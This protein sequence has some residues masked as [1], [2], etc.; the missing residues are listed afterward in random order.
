MRKWNFTYNL[1]VLN[2]LTQSFV[3]HPLNSILWQEMWSLEYWPWH[4][5]CNNLRNCQ[6]LMLHSSKSASD[7]VSK[8]QNWCKS[9]D[10]L[11]VLTFKWHKTCVKWKLEIYVA[12]WIGKLKTATYIIHRSSL[13]TK[14]TSKQWIV[15]KIYEKTSKVALEAVR[16]TILCC[17]DY[18]CRI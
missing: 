2:M 6:H 18:Q 9:F 15:V 5:C 8:T 12:H 14:L 13:S 7:L 16:L 1:K 3:K 4:S 17:K 11:T 10:K